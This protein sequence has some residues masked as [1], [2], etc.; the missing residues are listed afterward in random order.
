MEDMV[1]WT[2]LMFTR[3]AVFDET[4]TGNSTNVFKSVTETFATQL[5]PDITCQLVP[6]DSTQN[7]RFIQ[8]CTVSSFVTIYLEQ[9]KKGCWRTLN[10]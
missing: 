7:T 2:S 10:G 5:V 4:H 8:V 6:R 9:A 1:E 3:K